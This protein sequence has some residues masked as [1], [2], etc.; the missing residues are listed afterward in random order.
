LQFV[1][2]SCTIRDMGALDDGVRTGVGSKD[3]EKAPDGP[4]LDSTKRQRLSSDDLEASRISSP[5]PAH[6]STPPDVADDSRA[7]APA[8][9]SPQGIVGVNATSDAAPER[10]AS[11][12]SK[13]AEFG[14]CVTD[15]DAA[16]ALKK[17]DDK[18]DMACGWLLAE[19][20]EEKE[21][22]E[23][24]H[25]QHRRRE[26]DD[27]RMALSLQD[28][29]EK[30]QQNLQLQK[31]RERERETAKKTGQ[32][33]CLFERT[34]RKRGAPKLLKEHVG[35]VSSRRSRESHGGADRGRG[36]GAVRHGTSGR[37][38]PPTLGTLS[39]GALERVER[40]KFLQRPI[41]FQ[42]KVGSVCEA[43]RDATG[44]RSPLRAKE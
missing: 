23:H 29:E 12:V 18:L 44:T 31:D 15:A 21:R 1:H 25:D 40:H 35:G 13:I 36:D 16:L 19:S 8:R 2:E 4:G 41:M 10:V 39:D 11:L 42:G 3:K 24:E 14:G 20:T 5:S 26:Q 37:S 33:G 28:E 9:A 7:G 43:Y 38:A 6:L 22:L 32:V 17:F 34:T 27:L 30:W